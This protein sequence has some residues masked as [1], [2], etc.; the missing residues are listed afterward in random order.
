MLK[1][2]GA[3]IPDLARAM[4]DE[5]APKYGRD[6]KKVKIKEIGIRPGEKQH[7]DLMTEDE[8]ARSLD[9][10]ELYMILPARAEPAL[11]RG[12]GPSKLAGYSSSGVKML[13]YDELRKLCRKIVSS[14]R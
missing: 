10:G 2:D 6:P 9:S 11:Y 4:I 12:F 1:M 14:E 13:S 8:A 7:E 5:L 3:R